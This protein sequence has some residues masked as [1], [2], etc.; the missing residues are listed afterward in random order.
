MSSEQHSC[1]QNSL[2]HLPL[3]SFIHIAD[4][5]IGSYKDERLRQLSLDNLTIVIDQ[6]ISKKVN[7]VLLSG[8]LF[9]TA[10]PSIDSI[11]TT[12]QQFFRLKDANIPVYYICGSHDY[13]LS[14]KTMVHLL[15][16]AGIGIHCMKL[17]HNPQTGLFTLHP[18]IDKK[19][20]FHIYGMYGRSNGLEKSYYEQ[21]DISAIEADTAP[22]LF[23]LHTGLQE[24][25]PIPLSDSPSIQVLPKHC[26]YYAAGHIH[27]RHISTIEPYGIITYPGPVF[28]NSMSEIEQLQAGSYVYCSSDGQTLTAKHQLLPLSV[29]S[30]TIDITDKTQE[31]IEAQ[32][33][34]VLESP[35]YIHTIRFK[36]TAQFS[37]SRID[38]STI[39]QKHPEKIF[40]K[41]TAK[42]VEQTAVQPLVIQTQDAHE[43]IL[44]HLSDTSLGTELVRILKQEKIDGQTTTD[45]EQ[46]IIESFKAVLEQR[47]TTHK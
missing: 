22:K 31:Q 46:G 28:P 4:C 30:T 14:G 29:T 40:L 47:E 17:T 7:F 19:T 12:L 23:L 16:D 37:F 27:Y 26:V 18:I 38:F 13:S 2:S 44:S 33:H 5:H 8:D 42:V 1:E 43:E 25:L 21:L 20:G 10:V 24:L 35:S 3:C 9:N 32:I 15:E 39:S 41:N 34:T 11:R 6:C 45:F 36:G